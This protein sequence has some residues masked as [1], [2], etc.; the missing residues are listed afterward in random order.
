MGVP[1]GGQ[2]YRATRGAGT[3]RATPGDR[4]RERRRGGDTN[5]RAVGCAGGP[6]R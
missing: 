3:A 6:V 2:R 4:S 5:G 1:P